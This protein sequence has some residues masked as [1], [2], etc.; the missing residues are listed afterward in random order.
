MCLHC[1]YV[2]R[3]K[4]EFMSSAD[5]IISQKNQNRSLIYRYRHFV[6]K[7]FEIHIEVILVLRYAEFKYQSWQAKNG[8]FTI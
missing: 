5:D 2:A 8:V 6:K 1:I 3:V 4:Q 7:R